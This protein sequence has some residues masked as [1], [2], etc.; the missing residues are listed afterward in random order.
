MEREMPQHR[1]AETS[2]PLAPSRHRRIQNSNPCD[3]LAMR[4]GQRK[5]N[6]C[7]YVVSA[8]S[9]AVETKNFHRAVHVFGKAGFVVTTLRAVGITRAAQIEGDHG[10]SLG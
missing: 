5:G 2:L 8:D 7:S 10:V 4:E 3:G 6:H 1:V 9:V